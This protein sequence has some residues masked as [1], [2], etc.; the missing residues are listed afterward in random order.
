MSLV[1]TDLY[2]IN[3]AFRRAHTEILRFFVSSKADGEVQWQPVN[4]HGSRNLKRTF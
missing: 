4:W 3:V 1:T 2:F